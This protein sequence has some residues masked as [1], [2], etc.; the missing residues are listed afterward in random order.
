[1]VKQSGLRRASAEA[2]TQF[3]L[4]IVIGVVAVLVTVAATVLLI[5]G[6]TDVGIAGYVLAVISIIVGAIPLFSR[7]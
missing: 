1:M 5:T 2:L 7:D 4:L 6:T 3:E